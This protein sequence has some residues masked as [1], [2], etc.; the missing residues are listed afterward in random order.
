MRGL[1]TWSET[2]V[3]GLTCILLELTGQ[4]FVPH[5]LLNI[6]TRLGCL[7]IMNLASLQNVESTC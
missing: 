2:F 7:Y 3:V 5:R 4:S 1:E 6:G